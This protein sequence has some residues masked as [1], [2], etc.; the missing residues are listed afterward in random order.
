M[1][2]TAYLGLGGNLG[3]PVAT[4]A[5]ALR[6]IDA[7]ED[8]SVSAVS[9][10]FRTPPWGN[11]DQ[12]VFVNACARVR[13]SL[14]PRDLLALCLD[15][16]RAFKRE[17]RERWGPRTLDLDVL[18]YD[19]RAYRDDDLILPHP[20]IA[21]RGFVLVPLAEIAPDLV[22]GGKSVADLLAAVDRAGIEPVSEDGGWWQARGRG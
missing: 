7:R 4:M 15:T 6:T 20:R 17:R 9:R 22:I 18:D 3:D 11:T 19:G 5:A 1:S 16:E 21:E 14:G 8:T 12:P 2:S 10:V 13:T